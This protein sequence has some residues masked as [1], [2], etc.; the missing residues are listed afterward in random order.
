MIARYKD[1]NKNMKALQISYQSKL[2][3]LE[4]ELVDERLFADGLN[5][6][7]KNVE[8]VL[9]SG[10]ERVPKSTVKR[11]PSPRP[12]GANLSNKG[13]ASKRNLGD[14]K[15]SV[16]A[17]KETPGGGMKPKGRIEKNSIRNS[18]LAKLDKVLGGFEQ[19]LGVLQ[20][21]FGI[22]IAGR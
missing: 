17:K 20:E 7:F 10:S 12:R 9:G 1:S 5:S 15:R 19:K 14:K 4:N 16:S 21:K 6:L 8:T 3:K 2:R 18:T 13:G 11:T 22:E